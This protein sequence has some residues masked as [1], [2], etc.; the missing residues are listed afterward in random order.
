M[1]PLCPQGGQGVPRRIVAIRKQLDAGFFGIA[2]WQVK[3]MNIGR[4]MTK[5]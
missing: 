2:E 5:R 4:E 1:G 3:M